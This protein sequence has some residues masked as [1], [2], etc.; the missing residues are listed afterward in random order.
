MSSKSPAK[1]LDQKRALLRTANVFQ[2]TFSQTKTA[3]K[4]P[5]VDKPPVAAIDEQNAHDSPPSVEQEDEL[6]NSGILPLLF[7]KELSAFY[8]FE[9]RPIVKDLP[10]PNVEC[11]FIPNL[12]SYLGDLI[13]QAKPQ[14]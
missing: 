5:R 8:M 7:M 3:L 9:R 1:P 14:A 13:P 6:I 11:V 10:R 2:K 4:K 12:D